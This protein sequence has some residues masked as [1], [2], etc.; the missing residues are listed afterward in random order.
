M[1]NINSASELTNAI[2]LLEIEQEFKGQLLKQQLH[3][4]FES[5]KPVNILKGTFKSIITSPNLIDNII[6][7]SVGIATGYLSKKIV[8][9]ASSNI[10]RKLLGSVLQ[11]GVTNSVSQHP[12]AIKLLGQYIF[13][14]IFSKKNHIEKVDN[15]EIK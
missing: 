8:V 2:Q 4:T 6:G 1:Q 3:L 7:T 9:G 15:Y 12:E 14:H 13:K 10:I 5:F 11:I